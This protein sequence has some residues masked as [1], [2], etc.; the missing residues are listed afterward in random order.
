MNEINLKKQTTQQNK[1]LVKYFLIFF[2]PV[3]K[4]K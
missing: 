4:E 1:N 2:I 3:Q